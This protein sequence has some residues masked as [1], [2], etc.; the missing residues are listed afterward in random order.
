MYQAT[1]STAC[2]SVN[3]PKNRKLNGVKADGP[4][5]GPARTPNAPIESSSWNTSPGSALYRI[6][7]PP[8]GQCGSVRLQEVG[9]YQQ[10]R[11]ISRPA[12]FIRH[13]A[14]SAVHQVQMANSR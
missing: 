2:Q 6:T 3:R 11:G 7:E 13:M 5:P 14:Y 9:T 8:S 10:L 12:E 4:I 1:A